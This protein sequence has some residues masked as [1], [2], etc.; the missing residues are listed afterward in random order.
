VSPNASLTR[1]RSFRGPNACCVLLMHSLHGFQNT[2]CNPL[3]L[4]ILRDR[5]T[6]VLHVSKGGLSQ[7]R[8]SSS[9]SATPTKLA[10][11][12][13]ELPINLTSTC[14]SIHGP[15]TVFTVLVPQKPELSISRNPS[16]KIL[17]C[18]C[19]LAGREPSAWP[20]TIP[21]LVVVK[22]GTALNFVSF[23]TEEI[24]QIKFVVMRP[25]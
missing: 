17:Q 11:T 19:T 25:S 15:Y 9:M 12:S 3:F 13:I 22:H 5:W 24:V 7:R 16:A 21:A 23:R 2:S 18:T 8:S 4:G 10:C 1:I 20:I 6:S 14:A